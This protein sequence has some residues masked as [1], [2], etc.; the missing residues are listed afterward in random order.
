MWMA[1]SLFC[2][3]HIERA[4]VLP[5]LPVEPFQKRIQTGLRHR[6]CDTGLRL[7]DYLGRSNRRGRR[8]VEMAVVR[9]FLETEIWVEE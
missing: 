9:G 6:G 2:R 3:F 7:L 5:G 1:T 8:C 4:V